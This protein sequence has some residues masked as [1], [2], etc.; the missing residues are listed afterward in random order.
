MITWLDGTS[1]GEK[2]GR[3]LLECMAGLG[4][5]ALNIIPDRNWNVADP[6]KRA[7]KQANLATIVEA[8][9]SMALP[10]N[11]GTEMNKLGL[12]FVD[13]LAGDAL[14]PFKETFTRGARIMV[15]H[16]LLLRYARYS[17][18]GEAARND[19][20]DVRARNAFFERVGAMPP[21]SRAR[22]LELEAM[23][24]E[25]ALEWFRST[26]GAASVA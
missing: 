5:C 17:Y 22:A 2:D 6:K 16:T 21:L 4:A 7:V 20:R 23:G 12:P 10:I 9:D 26:A 11:I 14:R 24:P 18:V 15:G 19:F 8:A 13:D 1:D 25:R 3:A